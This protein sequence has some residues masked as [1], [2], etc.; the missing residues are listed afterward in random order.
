MQVDSII[1]KPLSLGDTNKKVRCIN[2]YKFI[3]NHSTSPPL[4]CST[5]CFLSVSS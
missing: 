1:A 3:A 5:S 2:C 4:F